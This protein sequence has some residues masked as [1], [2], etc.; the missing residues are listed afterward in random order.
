MYTSEVVKRAHHRSV[1]ETKSLLS[2]FRLISRHSR[3][4]YFNNSI[5][6]ENPKVQTVLLINLISATVAAFIVVIL[7]DKVTAALLVVD[8]V[9]PTMVEIVVVVAVVIIMV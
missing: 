7:V 2:Q 6:P 1:E 3:M 8:L 5:K 4:M 9:E